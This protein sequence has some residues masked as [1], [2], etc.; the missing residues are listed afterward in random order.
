MAQPFDAERLE[1]RGEPA[2]VAEGIW[3][4]R[5]VS[6]AGFSVSRTG[7]LAY[8]NSTL[9][10]VQLTW[11]IG[12]AGRWERWAPRIDT[13]ITHSCRRTDRAVAIVAVQSESRT[14]G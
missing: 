3:T 1:L 11:S 9:F 10:N 12:R 13:A 4:A 6:Q 14:C 5:P 7:V 8:V 2:A